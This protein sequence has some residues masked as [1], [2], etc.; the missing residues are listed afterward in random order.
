V[1]TVRSADRTR[2][3]TGVQ[4][5][6]PAC[7]FSYAHVDE[8][9][10]GGQLGLLHRLL[11]HELRVQSGRDFPVFRDRDHLTWGQAWE[12]R[13]YS[14]LDAANVLLP[15]ISPSYLQSEQCVAELR[16]FLSRE[17]RLG[18]AGLILPIYWIDIGPLDPQAHPGVED[19]VAVLAERQFDDWRDRRFHVARH[20]EAFEPLARRIRDA[21]PKVVDQSA[22]RA[23]VPTG[24]AMV[25]RDA[26]ADTA[27]KAL[28]RSVG[29]P[30]VEPALRQAVTVLHLPNLRIGDAATLPQAFGQD[31]V[32]DLQRTVNDEH[33]SPPD[34]V[35]VTGDLT[36]TARKQEF[37]RAAEVLAFLAEA[38]AIPREHIAVVP[39][40]R[41]VNLDLCRGYF[42]SCA[43]HDV[44]PQP[45]YWP[46]WMH[47]RAL[48]TDLY[49]DT[50][51]CGFMVDQEWSLFEMP[52]L[53]TA[54]A[55]FNTTFA[56]SHETPPAGSP[57]AERAVSLGPGQAAWFDA[58][59]AP[60]EQRGWLRIGVRHHAPSHTAP[61]HTA[62]GHTAPG[63]AR[64]PS[65]PAFPGAERP[66]VDEPEEHAGRLNPEPGT[67]RLNLLLHGGPRRAS[68]PARPGSADPGGPLVLGV[69]PDR[70]QPASTGHYQL[71]RVE[72]DGVHRV[73]RE[74]RPQQGGWGPPGD[75][76]PAGPVF[77][78]RNWRDVG[79]ALPRPWGRPAVERPLA[80]ESGPALPP[81]EASPPDGDAPGLAEATPPASAG[82]A[83]GFLARVVEATHLR[84]PGATVTVLRSKVGGAPYLR[85]A[86]AQDGVIRQF[87]VGICENGVDESQVLAFADGVHR[88]YA[89]TD[90]NLV[91]EL[92]YSGQ[93]AAD[94]LVAAAIR[95]GIQLT[96]YLEYQGLYDLRPY[97]T[98]QAAHLA[99]DTRYRPSLYVPQRLAWLEPTGER[100]ADGALDQ[101]V[102]ALAGDG[103]RV[104]VLLGGAGQG[105]TFLLRELVRVLPHRC[106]HLT[107]V[108]VDLR[109][110]EKAH[111]LDQLLAMHF[112]AADEQRFD[113]Q[114]FRYLL[115]AGR[116]VLLF[117]GFDELSF[118]V[119]Y[120][121]AAE[122]LDR[123]LAGATG[124]A[125]IVI[126]SRLEHFR[127]TDQVR[128]ALG[129]RV[130]LEPRS[131]LARLERFT[132]EQ[133]LEFLVNLFSAAD[134]PAGGADTNASS[135]G[136]GGGGGEPSFDGTAERRARERLAAIRG[137][138]NLVD[139]ARNPRMLGFVATLDP[140]RL[141][142]VAKPDGGSDATGLYRELVS[143]WI[144]FEVAR[145]RP[146][147]A[148]ETLDFAARWRMVTA[149]AVRMWRSGTGTVSLEELTSTAAATLAALLEP[150]LELDQATHLAGSGTL[151]TRGEDG[152]FGFVHDSVPDYLVAADLATQLRTGNR[153][154]TLALHEMSPL[155][156]EFLVS[157]TGQEAARG[158]ARS[159]LGAGVPA[160]PERTNALAVARFLG[161]SGLTDSGLAAGRHEALDL[162]GRQLHGVDLTGS[163]L[164]GCTVTHADLTGADLTGV[165][166]SGCDFTGA[167]LAGAHLVGARLEYCSLAEADL[168]SADLT[169]ATLVGCSLVGAVV[170]GSRWE[171]AALI[172]PNLDDRVGASPELADAAVVGR[173]RAKAAVA[174]E[175]GAL[176]LAFTADG[177]RLQAL[178]AAGTVISW[179][180][181]TGAASRPA[182]GPRLVTGLSPTGSSPAPSVTVAPGGQRAAGRLDGRL[183]GRLEV[184]DLVTGV[185]HPVSGPGSDAVRALTFS[186]DAALLAGGDDET[187]TLWNADTGDAL[188]RLAAPRGG[189]AALAFRSDGG[190]LA[191]AGGGRDLLV[192]ESATGTVHARLTVPGRSAVALAFASHGQ[193]ACLDEQGRVCLVNMLNSRA[194]SALAGSVGAAGRL[195]VSPDGTLLAAGGEERLLLWDLADGSPRARLV[196]HIGKV[197]AVAFSPDG[198]LLASAGDDGTIRLWSLRP[199]EKS[200]VVAADG[201]AVLSLA[202]RPD[203]SQVVT[204]GA[205][206]QVWP[207]AVDGPV[208]QL[209][210]PGPWIRSVAYSPDGAVLAYGG[211]DGV[212]HLRRISRPPDGGPAQKSVAAGPPLRLE[213]H[214]AAIHAVAFS[215]DGAQLATAGGDGTVR[216]WD[217][218]TGAETGPTIITPWALAVAFAP[219]GQRLATGGS[220]GRV[221]IWDA[222][223]GR[224]LTQQ[225][226]RAYWVR[227]VAFSSNGKL[228]ASGGDDGMVRLWD[229]M[230]GQDRGLLPCY[231][232]AVACVAFSPDSSR[233]ASGGQDG[234]IRIWDLDGGPDG[235]R[236]LAVLRGHAEWVWSV[237]FTP[238]GTGLVSGGSDGTVR[239]WRLPFT[240]AATLVHLPPDGWAVLRPD[241]SYKLQGNSGGRLWWSVRHRRFEPG[242]LDGHLPAVRRLPAD[243]PLP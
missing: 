41:D 192:W 120:E 171:G 211:D 239:R 242:E 220:D 123:L 168:T 42:A 47:Y 111:S 19:V 226:S 38:L 9:Q 12:E 214:G 83:D 152:R 148:A 24:P 185:S 166:A 13:I 138:R 153:P 218:A 203:G 121:K 236:E 14:V 141:R 114:Q 195:C 216:R 225:P 106:P 228:L 5:V 193:L 102:D 39:G 2:R 165:T 194:V 82:D 181:R 130:E 197:S 127:S 124:D 147:G 107:P 90:P 58:A 167:S 3:T 156:V 233:L 118:R 144:D 140:E 238:D 215:P 8:D 11:T 163:T 142:R 71:L 15:I 93:R 217:A 186:P 33:W 128:T 150:G 146:P 157:E 84:K 151:L 143:D 213:R 139:L 37:V 64:G 89:A 212:T 136:G 154:R 67:A 133:I 201:R 112:M 241:E 46:K 189:T 55:G 51:D 23:P 137:V 45:P 104:V 235:P 149:L 31:L 202:C 70:P 222:G 108:L 79:T 175:P 59:L 243:L 54:V 69:Y 98:R 91:S 32:D 20:P 60:W 173:D 6:E 178:V 96:S 113:R 100:I 62:P 208:E 86:L 135:G 231:T 198:E 36:A 95:Q 4:V 221:R 63:R 184:V 53:S 85:V 188:V 49:Q 204:G 180:C 97:L 34:L 232:Q 117:D 119:T 43:G 145:A 183:D 92:V 207:V 205:S 131:R 1:P 134:D 169:D 72:A 161:E 35:V 126:A 74:Y 78:R 210:E 27:G 209:A 94:S 237:A 28:I 16:W 116:L 50:T 176:A 159:V 177:T 30:P 172:A 162:S 17:R 40:P 227:A 200:K 179:D 61:S 190:L 199:A 48:L 174:P 224:Q 81:V 206:V 105:K 115:G 129:R 132:E 7:F 170:T 230:T 26:A 80:H 110:L 22:H 158:W 25:A 219:S 223:S 122:H 240:P 21:F 191:A 109:G 103:A 155:M 18:H 73:L 75:G 57:G 196:G 52:H 99:A 77:W 68:L 229:G 187:I 29:V 160:G 10:G 125:K 101:V 65:G 56:T 87:A 234:T 164:A 76:E 66:W 88:S 182:A 44:E